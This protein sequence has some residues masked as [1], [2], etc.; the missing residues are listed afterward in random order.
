M[1]KK[2]RR[3]CTNRRRER[4]RNRFC[5]FVLLLAGVL[6]PVHGYA[7]GF[8][9][10]RN[11]IDAA[12]HHLPSPLHAFFKAHGPWLHDHVNDADL[13]K[14]T[15]IDEEIRHY[16]DL[17]RYSPSMDSLQVWFPMAYDEACERWSED[18]LR[19]HGIGPWHALST[20]RRLI[21]AFDQKDEAAI[22]RHGADL[23]HYISDLHVPLHTSANYDGKLSNQLGIHALWETQLPESFMDGYD[24]FPSG[25]RAIWIENTEE[26]IWQ[27]VLTSHA[28]LDSVF[29]FELETRKA[30]DGKPIDAYVERGR[31]RQLMRSPLFAEYYHEVLDGQV[32]RRMSASSALV[33]SLWYSAWIE[34]GAPEMAM[35]APDSRTRWK[36]V[37]DWLFK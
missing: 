26:A 9:A 25:P 17:D 15:V 29:A 14:H 6:N 4:V 18:S 2:C 1:R 35:K 22:L 13:R 33:S 7:W 28:C 20:Y 11:I 34:A 36:K 31:T 24:L 23:A 32:E 3:I 10:H 30:F 5:C 8:S 27:T 37:L 12:I 16:I 19:A 21:V